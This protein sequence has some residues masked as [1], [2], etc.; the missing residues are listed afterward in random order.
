MQELNADLQDL[1]ADIKLDSFCF[2]CDH[3]T[4]PLFEA[5]LETLLEVPRDTDYISVN[6]V[7]LDVFTFGIWLA[8]GKKEEYENVFSK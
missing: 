3:V 2:F 7:G 1:F 5:A 6:V 4:H 8:I